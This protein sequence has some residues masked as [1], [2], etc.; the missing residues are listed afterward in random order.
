MRAKEN[1]KISGAWAPSPTTPR[2]PPHATAHPRAN[3][4]CKYTQAGKLKAQVF[5][6]PIFNYNSIVKIC[7][8]PIFQFYKFQFA[9]S[10]FRYSIFDLR[11]TRFNIQFPFK[12]FNPLYSL[13]RDG[14][15]LRL[16]SYN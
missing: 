8:C 5:R 1:R 2:T 13:Y 12:K 14:A 6:F 10:H 7:Q 9:I 3:R 16:V 15:D 4:P 11:C